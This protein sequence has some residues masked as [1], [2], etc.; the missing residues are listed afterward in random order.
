MQDSGRSEPRSG[1]DGVV[2]H[3]LGPNATFNERILVLAAAG[4]L[5]VA[6]LLTADGWTPTQYVVGIFIAIDL[7]GGVVANATRSA[8]TWFHREDRSTLRQLAFVA[9]HVHPFAIS[10]VF[11]PIDPLYGGLIYGLVL[12]AGGIVLWMPHTLKRP[13]AFLAVTTLLVLDTVLFS[14]PDALGWFIPVF[15][16]KL[17]VGHLIPERSTEL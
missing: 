11:A 15:G 13:L 9:G 14:V 5:T 4:G 6:T 12:L 3:L 7:G 10:V 1:L 2:D 16:L 8:K 17:L